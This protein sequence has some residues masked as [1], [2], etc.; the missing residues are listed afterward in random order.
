M[1][2]EAH[3]LTDLSCEAVAALD[4]RCF[5]GEAFADTWWRKAVKGQGACAWYLGNTEAVQAFCLF[6]RVLDEAELLRI[7]VAPEA[8]RQGL[9]RQLLQQAMHELSSVGVRHLFLEVRA[10]NQAAQGLYTGLGWRPTGVR[11]D[12]YPQGMEREDALLF[13]LDLEGS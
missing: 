8:R 11:K 7:A 3:P 5:P 10:S 12:Y 2:T 6:S 13:G 1:Q 9:A 4:S